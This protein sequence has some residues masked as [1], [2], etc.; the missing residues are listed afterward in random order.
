MHG[1][2]TLPLR[3]TQLARRQ[4]RF[5]DALQC[6]LA[7]HARRPTSRGILSDKLLLAA[8]P[9]PAAAVAAPAATASSSVGPVH[10][11]SR[12]L[13]SVRLSPV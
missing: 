10:H 8:V 11:G 7:H 12:G 1:F 9:C 13:G 2:T 4:Q 5:H 3:C 6:R